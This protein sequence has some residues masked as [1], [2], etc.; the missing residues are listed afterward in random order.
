MQSRLEYKKQ[1]KILIRKIPFLVLVLSSNYI[2]VNWT[3][4]CTSVNILQIL[5]QLKI[6]NIYTPTIAVY[7]QLLN[8]TFLIKHRRVENKMF[9]QYYTFRLWRIFQFNANSDL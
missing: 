5:Q 2:Y 7:S 3:V 9:N 4:I 1:V 8:E 6:M